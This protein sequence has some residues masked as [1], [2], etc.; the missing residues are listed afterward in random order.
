MQSRFGQILRVPKVQQISYNMGTRT[1]PDMYALSPRASGM[2][3]RQSTRAY[4]ITLYIYIY[5]IQHGNVV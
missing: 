1:F 4:V 5:I 3:I 2:H